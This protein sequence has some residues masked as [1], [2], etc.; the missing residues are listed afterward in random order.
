[1]HLCH[2]AM[3]GDRYL[4]RCLALPCLHQP[5]DP[6]PSLVFKALVLLMTSISWILIGK[7]WIEYPE[8]FLFNEEYLNRETIS[9]TERQGQ[10]MNT[11][12]EDTYDMEWDKSQAFSPVHNE[13]LESTR[14]PQF[15][16]MIYP[17]DVP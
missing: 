15:N 6:F 2:S 13:L 14:N 11:T 3:W 5:E 7:N 9:C 16:H 4:A 8:E 10:Y 12:E 1:M 17:G